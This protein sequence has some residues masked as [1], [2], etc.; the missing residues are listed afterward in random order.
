M[1]SK[2][3]FKGLVLSL[4][5]M[6][7]VS[8][9][10]DLADDDHYKLPSWAK[11][12][13][14]E[15]MQGEGVYT[16]FLRGLQL[17][18]NEG[19]VNGKSLVTVAAPDDNAF[20]SFLSSKGY[21]SI[22][23]M[24][25]AEPDYTRNLIGMHLMYYAFDWDK[26]VNF[27]PAEG[28]G[29][30]EEQKAVY[31]G[32]Y[33]KHRTHSQ[34]AIEKVT[35]DGVEQEVYH[36]ERFLP[37]FST[38][39]FETKG[40]DAAANYNYFYPGTTWYG[41][42]NSGDGFNI[43]NAKV[44]NTDNLITDNGYLYKVDRVIE[45]LN[46]I[47]DELRNNSDY[48]QFLDI[49]DNY[50]TYEVARTDVTDALGRNVYV[51]THGS[52]PSIACEWPVATKS[53]AYLMMDQLEKAGYNVFAPT[54]DALDKF[55]QTYWNKN[56]GYGSMAEL[57]PLIK[58][59]FVMQMFAKSDF[60]VFPE[61]IEKGKVETVYGTPINV[62]MNTISQ[63]RRRICCNGVLYGIDDLTAPAIF[64]SVAAPAFR[65]TTYR[66]Y[67]YC[68]D[69]SNLVSS[70]AAENST[71]VKLIPSNK[72]F[73]NSEPVMRLETMGNTKQLQAWSDEANQFVEMGNGIKLA[74]VN[75][76]TADAVSE[77]PESGTAV[78]NT[79]VPFNYWYVS[80]G[81]ITT[82]AIFNNQLEIDAMHVDDPFFGFHELKPADGTAW[83]NGKAYTYDAPSVFW[84]QTGDGLLSKLSKGN[85][86]NLEYY[87]YAQ[88]LKLAGLI[89]GTYVNLGG[90]SD[91]DNLRYV[92]FAPTNDVVKEHLNEIPGCEKLS[93]NAD[94]SIKGTL[95]TA[96][97]ALLANWLR[98]CCISTDKNQI[99]DYPFP[100]SSCKGKFVNNDL[101][102]LYINDEGSTLS[103]R[104]NDGQNVKVT[105]K[106]SY[107]PF[108]YYDACLHFVDELIK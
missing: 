5:T 51:R 23:E 50:M 108:A 102:T 75:M 20:S 73:R 33:Y 31:A 74:I 13:A 28:D 25:K 69:G 66:Y 71:F 88:L 77:L 60:L 46:T 84:A 18:G 55:F 72:Q 9:C 19:I 86:V 76:H 8:S 63:N 35:I 34:D 79:S 68:L 83:S 29:A 24:Y 32:Y 41:T 43:A 80:D 49:Y 85:D 97:K 59:Y 64:S 90:D 94:G 62:D 67:L 42:E 82:N 22:D 93:L 30:T 3:K 48:S 98:S 4:L 106:Y 38:K 37:V 95:T 27:R 11:G 105:S 7:M 78:V 15:M 47:Y 16:T 96:N 2:T 87:Y 40:I 104:L 107:F 45:P 10:S 101:T 39:L 17:T 61:E 12:N 100:G 92:I 89:T 57:D 44:N 56:Q 70:L 53:N 52:L 99:S 81:R 36:D 21:S 1:Q 6:V 65:D 103:V 14:Y 58:Q 91:S 54:N 26:M